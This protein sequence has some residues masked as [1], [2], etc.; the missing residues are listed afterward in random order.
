MADHVESSDDGTNPS[1]AARAL[2]K[3]G[4]S[5]GGKAR[6]KS[7]TPERRSEIAR[8]AVKT[9]WANAKAESEPPILEATHGDESHPLR[10][11]GLEIPCYVLEDGR[12]VLI[13]TGMITAL[14][15]SH[16]GTGGQGGDRL[17]KFA[18][19]KGLNPFIT[20]ELQDRTAHPILF[21]TMGGSLAYGYEAT[22]LADICE[23]VLS[24]RDAGALQ[25][26]QLHIA[27][28]CEILV[29]GALPQNP[30]A[31][32]KTSA[33]VYGCEAKPSR[34]IIEGM[35]AQ[36]ERIMPSAVDEC[37]AN[38][39]ETLSHFPDNRRAAIVLGELYARK[40]DDP[41]KAIEVILATKE[42]MKARN[43]GNPKDI[44]DIHFNCA[45]YCCFLAAKAISDEDIS[46]LHRKSL[47][48]LGES[49]RL[50]P[51][52]AADARDDK[53]LD[54]IRGTPEFTS[55]VDAERGA[56]NISETANG[57]QSQP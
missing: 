17:A 28:Q 13:Q 18:T 32:P 57:H 48:H 15:M 3:L 30:L 35:V 50:W 47:E 26:Q 9:R 24:A 46:I 14:G 52:N 25:K 7:L 40:K 51:A 31:C 27:K 42:Q 41:K 5:K 29:R 43:T 10:I 33:L 2:G 11:G 37:I 21:R 44:A 6:A 49:L 38:L 53:D 16:G 1:E 20:Q 34:A 12:R 54:P 56:G 55:M 36:K 8:K 45:C 39:E 19:G 22:V 4:A 23:A